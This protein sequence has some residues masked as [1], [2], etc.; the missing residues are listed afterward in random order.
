MRTVISVG[1]GLVY[2][3]IEDLLGWRHKK[4]A[5]NSV[6]IRNIRRQKMEQLENRD[7]IRRLTEIDSRRETMNSN[8]PDL[9]HRSTW[10]VRKLTDGGASFFGRFRKRE[11]SLREA[12]EPV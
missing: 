3:R 10:D 8:R 1:F 11:K 12:G 2:V 6:A 9:K 4:A 5:Y 7:R